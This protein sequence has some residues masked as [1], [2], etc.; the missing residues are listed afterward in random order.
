VASTTWSGH[1]AT[2]AD[3]GG[4]APRD[5]RSAGYDW[6]GARGDKGLNQLAGMEALPAAGS[7]VV[8]SFLSDG[9]GGFPTIQDGSTSSSTAVAIAA[10]LMGNTT[11]GATTA[12]STSGVSLYHAT[13][14]GVVGYAGNYNL[15]SPTLTAGEVVAMAPLD[16]GSKAWIIEGTDSML[17][18]SAPA[19]GTNYTTPGSQYLLGVAIHGIAVG[20]LRGATAPDVV[21]VG[22]ETAGSNA[23]VLLNNG[24]GAFGLPQK[25]PVTATATAV[26]TADV[27]GG[28]TDIVVATNNQILVFL[29]QG[30]G[31]F[32][33]TPAHT[34]AAQP[35]VTAVAVADFN[36]D[37]KP[38]IAASSTGSDEVEIFTGNG[39]GSFNPPVVFA[40]GQAIQG[41]GVADFNRDTK[42]DIV[43][44]GFFGMYLLQNSTM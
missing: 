32:A 26:A 27:D 11:M 23:Y 12:N 41:I 40:A 8:T 9:N 33:T 22:T 29:N 19:A 42:P 30:G 20:S 17:V 13:S 25:L 4:A 1:E 24:S 14:A 5:A 3:R 38:D 39:D 10:G 28:G 34:Y 31:T 21:A 43:V 2:R 35:T 7:G 44:S 37:G 36:G 16:G 18:V 6:A 15:T